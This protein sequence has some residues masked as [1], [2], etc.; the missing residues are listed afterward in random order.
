MKH[1]QI[2]IN[3]VNPRF[4]RA[5]KGGIELRGIN[6]ENAQDQIQS[7]IKEQQLPVVIFDIDTSV[8]SISIRE[9]NL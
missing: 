6:F 4:T 7:I 5:Y 1:L 8:K 9:I 3:K 2:I